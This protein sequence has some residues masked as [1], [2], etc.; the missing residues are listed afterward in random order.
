MN[1]H[2]VINN[3]YIRRF[4]IW[5]IYFLH[6]TLI[7]TIIYAPWDVH[8]NSPVPDK[9]FFL[10]WLLIS[11]F[12]L[13]ITRYRDLGQNCPKADATITQMKADATINKGC[14]FSVLIVKWILRFRPL[15]LYAWMNHFDQIV[16]YTTSQYIC[17]K[18]KATSNHC[19]STV[20]KQY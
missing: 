7:Q 19:W 4:S 15:I 12:P 18:L 14:T 5:M 20:N 6:E 17:F 2:H 13:F 3:L 16:Y 1:P 10:K 8:R 11:R 9:S